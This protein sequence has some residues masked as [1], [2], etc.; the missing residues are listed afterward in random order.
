MRVVHKWRPR[1]KGG[2]NEC[3]AE[4]GDISY[5]LPEFIEK[6]EGIIEDGLDF[7]DY[8]T[9]RYYIVAN[10]GEILFERKLK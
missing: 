9:Y 5:K 3:T 8:D 2:D 4:S 1:G 10:N 6:V 7:D